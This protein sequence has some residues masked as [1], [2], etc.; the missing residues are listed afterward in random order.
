[1]NKILDYYNNPA[2]EKTLDD[3]FIKSIIIHGLVA[4]YQMFD[5]GNTRLARLLQHVKMFKLTNQL[6]DHKLILPSLYATRTYYP[7]RT[8]YRNLIKELVINTGTESWNNWI[9]FNLKRIEDKLFYA[10]D[11]VSDIKKLMKESKSRNI[12]N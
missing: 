7:H 8:E 11:K 6:T 10:T 3:I 9:S 12:F 5:D 2:N 4:S 1:M